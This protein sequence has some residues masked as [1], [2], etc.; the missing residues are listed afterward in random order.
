MNEVITFLQLFNLFHRVKVPLIQRDYAQGRETE[1]EV[2]D[3][4]L[5]ALFD[6]LQAPNGQ[7]NLDFVYGSVEEAPGN[8]NTF[9]P[10]DGQQRLTTLFLLY[11]YLAWADEKVVH[12]QT[13]LWDA[14]Q[15]HSR[16]TYDVRPSS[17]EFFDRLVQYTPASPPVEVGSVKRLLEEQ[18]WFFLRW[19]LDPTIQ[20][21]LVM[22]DAIHNLFRNR[23]GLYNRLTNGNN[24]ITFQCLRLDHFGLTDDLYIK[25]NARG[26]PLTPLETFKARYGEYLREKFPAEIRNLGGEDVPIAVFFENRMDTR[27]TN[28][29]W[30]KR[31][32]KTHTFDAQLMNFF[33]A[34]VRISLEPTAESFNEDTKLLGNKPLAGTFGLFHERNWLTLEFANNLFSLLD[35][36]SRNA[37]QLT[38]V[39]ADDQP[40]FNESAF[41]KRAINDPTG[42]SYT[43]LVQLAA[44]VV[45]LRQHPGPV[46][47]G[48]LAEWMRVVRNLAVNSDIERPEEYG[49]CLTGLRTLV[50]HS[51]EI[52]E[53]LAAE[54]IG[55]IGF[56]FQR[57]REEVLKAK[58]LLANPG[59]RTRIDQA[60]GN[61]YF[62]GQIEFLLD[63]CGVVEKAQ[64]M[65][66]GQW[67][68][69]GHKN[70]QNIF[71]RYRAKAQA[72]F[73]ANGLDPTIAPPQ[74]WKRAL[75]ACGDYLF[76]VGRNYSFLTNAPSDPGSWKRFLRGNDQA[77]I[78]R[79]SYLKNLWHQVDINGSV[80]AQL[81]AIIVNA[82]IQQP[83]RAVI[84]RH[85]EV[86]SY[87]EQQVIR[88]E[89][90]N[91]VYL[92]KRQ[93]MNGYHAELFSYG[94]FLELGNLIAGLAPLAL[95]DYVEETTGDAQPHVVLEFV[96]GDHHVRF[97]VEWASDRFRVKT[98]WVDANRLPQVVQKLQRHPL[99][100]NTHG[101][102]LTRLARHQEIHQR[103]KQLAQALGAFLNGNGA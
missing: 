40:Y 83:W 39:L 27:W 11:W 48:S 52:L 4:F 89:H 67:T 25:M 81:E 31:D 100:F 72:T 41:F 51:A 62:S 35:A 85:P 87:C 7:I 20:S 59:W 80:A 34:V 91:N 88:R 10:L 50:P 98:R 8:L 12:F 17:K 33:L 57:V 56:S 18:S 71:D 42:F 60:E 3:H 77:A 30:K 69:Q 32:L 75:L 15:Q 49:R 5:R 26:K 28:L 43:E 38:P 36:W 21:T 82:N 68:M 101:E 53:H 54:D 84:V 14:E 47:S 37:E 55:P 9:L 2:R 96:H 64:H 92:L 97:V 65:P 94:L 13:V 58:L 24:A 79:R 95:L 63:F 73:N 103:L 78:Q 19:R 76:P 74:L 99:N 29:F 102:W 22:L 1:R 23:E 90:D 45:Y 16:F 86:I 70:L 44:L 46:N 93:Q 6:A 66:I 61:Q